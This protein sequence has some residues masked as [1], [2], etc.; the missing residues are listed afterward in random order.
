MV[1]HGDFNHPIQVAAWAAIVVGFHLLLCKSYLVPNSALEFKTAHQLQCRDV[2]Y[3]HGMVLVNIKW[4]KTRHIGNRIMLLLRSKSPACPVA[5]LK[6]LFLSV[7]ASPMDPLF[8]FHHNK[9]YSQSRLSILTYSLLMLYLCHWLE[10]ASFDA[11]CYSCH[12]LH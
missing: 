2:Y 12:S 1:K 10:S 4:F 11:Y 7:T 3:H 9:A 5:A 8:T 6:R